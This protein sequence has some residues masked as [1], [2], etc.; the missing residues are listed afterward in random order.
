[1][2]VCGSCPSANIICQ[3]SKKVK[4]KKDLSIRSTHIRFTHQDTHEIEP[5]PFV[6]SLQSA[7]VDCVLD[8]IRPNGSGHR[9]TFRAQ[10]Q[11]TKFL[12]TE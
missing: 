5:R 10:I 9:V 11:R 12:P 2:C 8:A 7:P 4:K 6:E 1:M 3:D